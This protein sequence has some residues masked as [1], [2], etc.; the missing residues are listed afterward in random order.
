MHLRSLA[1][2]TSVSLLGL[3]GC[4]GSNENNC[5]DAYELISYQQALPLD[6][7]LRSASR[8]PVGLW[9]RNY[10]INSDGDYSIAL[11]LNIS[12][13]ESDDACNVTFTPVSESI[14]ISRGD[15]SYSSSLTI[16]SEEISSTPG[17][18]KV[19]LMVNGTADDPLNLNACENQALQDFGETGIFV[20][21]SSE[22]AGS[23]TVLYK[24][25]PTEEYLNARLHNAIQDYD[26]VRFLIEKKDM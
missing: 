9:D 11:F 25:I 19:M 17:A 6:S 12:M 5:S 23:R 21:Y 3:S 20:E 4:A 22:G 15:G 13:S 16:P 10:S 18:S 14:Q 7:S 8:S 2:L 24:F 1:L 26:G